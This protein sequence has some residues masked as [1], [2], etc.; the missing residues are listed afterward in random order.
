[1]MLHSVAATTLIY[2]FNSF[3]FPIAHW[4]Y[5]FLRSFSPHLIH[6]QSF[7]LR[8][9]SPSYRFSAE[10]WDNQSKCA[11]LTCTLSFDDNFGFYGQSI[12]ANYI[13]QSKFMFC[14]TYRR[15]QQL[16]RI[17]KTRK[18]SRNKKKSYQVE[19]STL[20][21]DLETVEDERNSR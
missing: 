2:I 8:S 15:F 7:K 21:I 11:F 1:M 14:D 10:C 4:R 9:S 17:Y 6:C 20:T 3:F 12:S 19:V 13:F 5:F 16:Y 18:H